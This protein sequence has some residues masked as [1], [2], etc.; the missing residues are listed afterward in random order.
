MAPQP[1]GVQIF[2]VHIPGDKCSSVGG[3][4]SVLAEYKPLCNTGSW[5]QYGRTDCRIALKA[6]GFGTEDLRTG[7]VFYPTLN[8]DAAVGSRT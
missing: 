3:A 2:S 6:Q 7:F 4:V 5:K 1:R 8:A